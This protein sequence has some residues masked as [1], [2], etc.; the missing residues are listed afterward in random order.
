VVLHVAW[1]HDHERRAGPLLLL[2][3]REHRHSERGN[4][5]EYGHT[6]AHEG[7]IA[8]PPAFATRPSEWD[9]SSVEIAMP[10]LEQI[11]LKRAKRGPM[12]PVTDATLEAG[13]GLAGN[14]NRGGRRQVTIISA[15]RWQEMMTALGRDLSPATRRAN[16]LVSGL[17]LEGTRDRI[18]RIGGCRV[19]VNGETRPCERMEEAA[20]GLPAIMAERWGG[21]IYA[22]V[23]DDGVIRVGDE[24]AWVENG[25]EGS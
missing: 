19:R 3:R 10:R 21:G 5:H 14:A 20:P 17:G 15:E 25:V 13:A 4:E 16:L 6:R 8:A 22:E 24:V 11:W 23:L 18:L 2:R 7:R 12:D 9:G 1:N